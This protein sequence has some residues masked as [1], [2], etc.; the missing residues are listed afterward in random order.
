MLA[1]RSK[2]K[3]FDLDE[4]SNAT[5]SVIAR[6]VIVSLARSTPYKWLIEDDNVYVIISSIVLEA[7]VV[8]LYEGNKTTTHGWCI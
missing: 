3:M 4:D 1:T 6:G 2:V 8:L 5:T 7:E